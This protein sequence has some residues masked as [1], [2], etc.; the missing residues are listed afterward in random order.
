[1]ENN[2]FV[3]EKAPKRKQS[4][5]DFQVI[6]NAVLED[7]DDDEAVKKAA[8]QKALQRN[9]ERYREKSGRDYAAEHEARKKKEL[10]KKKQALADLEHATRVA[11]EK[12]PPETD[13]N[14]DFYSGESVSE[15]FWIFIAPPSL[16]ANAHAP[17][18][19]PEQEV[20]SIVKKFHASTHLAQVLSCGWCAE[21]HIVE[22]D[23]EVKRIS[24]HNP[25]ETV[26][27]KSKL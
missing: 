3:E 13:Y 14:D 25:Q 23:A 2:V 12:A 22:K 11:F 17:A 8:K 21:C 9:A 26:N 19:L 16:A 15:R 1:M 18:P 10:E 27:G 4:L 5:S 24:I 6:Q 7:L 20:D